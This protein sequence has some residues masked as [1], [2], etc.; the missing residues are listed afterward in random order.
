MTEIE[1]KEWYKSYK[2]MEYGKTINFGK[3]V[4]KKNDQHPL[5]PMV[6]NHHRVRENN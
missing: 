3:K 6:G 4:L 2:A 1:G 5:F